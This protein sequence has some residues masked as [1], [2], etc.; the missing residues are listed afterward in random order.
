[1]PDN[2]RKVVFHLEKARSFQPSRGTTEWQNMI[3]LVWWIWVTLSL[4]RNLCFVLE[5]VKEL[6]ETR[7]NTVTGI[8]FIY[9]YGSNRRWKDLGKSFYGCRSSLMFF[10]HCIYLRS[11]LLVFSDEQK[12][13]NICGTKLEYCGILCL[14]DK[15]PT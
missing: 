7:E 1:M 3:N 11:M 15:L 14:W 9:Y 5:W 12:S 6:E 13:W 2:I 4:L 10:V 8:F